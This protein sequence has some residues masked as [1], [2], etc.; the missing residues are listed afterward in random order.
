ML[1]FKKCGAFDINGNTEFLGETGT[2]HV[3]ISNHYTQ[4]D[5]P[6]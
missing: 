1:L 4:L 2:L 3:L 5:L 6:D